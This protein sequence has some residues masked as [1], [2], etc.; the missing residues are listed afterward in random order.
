MKTASTSDCRL[1]RRAFLSKTTRLTAGAA[2]AAGV[3]GF[4][5]IDNARGD[6]S[7]SDTIGFFAIG[8]TITLPTNDRPVSLW[9]PR[10][11]IAR[12]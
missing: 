5:G 12:V 6:F 10:L 8:D 9:T 4:S 7:E 3:S 2:M 11:S 1:G